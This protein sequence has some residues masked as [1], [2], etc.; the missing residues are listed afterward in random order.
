MG[1]VG[2]LFFVNIYINLLIFW[3]FFCKFVLYGYIEEGAGVYDIKSD[4]AEYD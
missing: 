2:S 1:T 4:F 3:Q